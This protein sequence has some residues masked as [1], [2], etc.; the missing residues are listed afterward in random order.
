MGLNPGYLLNF[1]FTLITCAFA[2]SRDANS[3]AIFNPRGFGEWQFVI[4]RGLGKLK[5]IPRGGDGLL[6]SN[7]R[8]TGGEKRPGTTGMGSLGSPWHP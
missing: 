4:S 7:H 6:N 2:T 5:P 8:G 1:F 3:P